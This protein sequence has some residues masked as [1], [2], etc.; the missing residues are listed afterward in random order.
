M[1]LQFTILLA[2]AA[3]LLLFNKMTNCDPEEPQLPKSDDDD[4]ADDVKVSIE[5]N[6]GGPMEEL[7]R[8]DEDDAAADDDGGGGGQGGEGTEED[9]PPMPTEPENTRDSDA[10]EVIANRQREKER[11]EAQ[12]RKDEKEKGFQ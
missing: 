2:I 9:V 1:R 5:Q 6:F 12:R 11:E 10:W 3:I 4:D 8:D 7:K